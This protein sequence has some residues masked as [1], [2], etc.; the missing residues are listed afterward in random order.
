MDKSQIDEMTRRVMSYSKHMNFKTF[1]GIATF[2]RANLCEDWRQVDVALV[3]LPTDAGPT[4]RTG[5]RHGP[6]EI[7][8]QSCNV[9]YYNPLTKVI[10]F[11]LARV[12]DIGDVPLISAFNLERVVAEIHEF[13]RQVHRA[14]VVP[15]TAGG[16]HS[17]SYPILK[18]LGA[19]RPVGLVHIDAHIDTTDRIADS[20]LHHGAPF[21]NAARDGVLDPKRTVHIAI[22][23]P[24]GEFE[25]FAYETGMAVIDIDR[26]YD[27]GVKG[28]VAEARRVVGDGP[29][30][31]SFD[32]DGLDPAYAPGT[33]TPVVGGITT[34]EGKRL[35]HGLRGLDIIGGDVVEVSPPFDAAGITALAGAQ[36]MFEILCL[37][38]E[39]FAKRS[40][41]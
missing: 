8:N 7:R 13:Y 26:F 39:A 3:G 15:V 28:V 41:K 36:M 29:A 27:L 12:A 16:D 14:G 40:K 10:P 33:G 31:I 6:R 25:Q 19:E 1:S 21:K 17:I 9:A 38:A 5:T 24:A 20:T 23:D 34:Y 37:A 22:R 2:F 11:E 30:Y 4:Q 18:A 32:V 35:L